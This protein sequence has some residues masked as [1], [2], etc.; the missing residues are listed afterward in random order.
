MLRDLM[1]SIGWGKPVALPAAPC[2]PPPGG[3][4]ANLE[5]AAVPPPSTAAATRFRRNDI[6][7][8]P[9]V[10]KEVVGFGVDIPV[11]IPT[12][13]RQRFVI[14]AVAWY[15]M[16]DGCEFE[17]VGLNPGLPPKVCRQLCFSPSEKQN[18]SRGK[19]Q[20]VSP[21]GVSNVRRS[22]ACDSCHCHLP[23]A[24][25]IR[26]GLRH[27]SAPSAPPLQVVMEREQSNPEFNFLF[28]VRL[29]EHAYYRWRLY[30]LAC[31]DSLR[32][33]RV[34]PFLMVERSSRWV[35]PPMTVGV[36]GHKTRA[37]RGGEHKQDL[38]LSDLQRDKFEDM[39]RTLTVERED[40]CAAMV[41]A[42]DNA[43]SGGA[44]WD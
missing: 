7:T 44:S 1:I 30:S 24:D 18:K 10:A 9:A 6:A 12:D 35:P 38:P 16:R 29:P 34:D 5:G 14:D 27:S 11:I 15:V 28:D 21:I 40:I 2:Y 26:H 32:S 20:E 17:Q 4:A 37:Q 31:G 25:N 39:L 33:W 19:Q 41:F 23:A 22:R 3:L 8:A 13:P 42:M 36:T 43:E